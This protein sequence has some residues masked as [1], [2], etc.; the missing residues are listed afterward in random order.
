MSSNTRVN[1]L[2]PPVFPNQPFLFPRGEPQPGTLYG[3]QTSGALGQ[4]LRQ[5]PVRA[6]QITGLGQTLRESAQPAQGVLGPAIHTITANVRPSEWGNSYTQY[7]R[8]G[9]EAFARRDPKVFNDTLNR[10]ALLNPAEIAET[11]AKGFAMFF[12]IDRKSNDWEF[13]QQPEGN[14]QSL[15]DYFDVFK[16]FGERA[17]DSELNTLESSVPLH[18][19]VYI[20]NALARRMY[21]QVG[22]ILSLSDPDS[23]PANPQ[24]QGKKGLVVG[25]GGRT[26]SQGLTNYW[27]DQAV[28]GRHLWLI[29]KRAPF[30]PFHWLAAACDGHPT[31]E[32]RTYR[33]EAG[34]TQRGLLFY[35]GEVIEQPLEFNS[36]TVC[37]LLLGRR[38][39]GSLASMAECADAAKMATRVQVALQIPIRYKTFLALTSS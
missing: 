21:K 8:L 22:M 36:A 35:C 30:R 15:A 23:S 3:Q 2:L 6:T 25:I 13:R 17:F 14:Y 33:D 32:Q 7:L 34:I 37:S 24:S 20:S 31:V 11:F 26:M 10:L 27:G 38:D 39:D 12:E 1:N 4:P 29:L 5:E 28:V 18:N 16:R 19:M 9:D